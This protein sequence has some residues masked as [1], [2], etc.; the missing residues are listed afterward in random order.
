MDRR[1]TRTK[2][3]IYLAFFDLLK[4][5]PMDEITITELAKAADID[6]RTFYNHYDTVL[7][8]FLEFKGDLQVALVDLLEESEAAGAEAGNPMDFSTF[9]RGLNTIME[10]HREFY[11]KLSKDKASMFLRYDCKDILEA[12][13]KEFYGNRYENPKT[14]LNV[15]TGYIAYAITGLGSDYVTSKTP[16]PADEF[17]AQLI[18]PLEAIWV[19]RK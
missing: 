6:R 17:W 15:Y 9:F 12:A 10:E 1:Q 5:K 8:V 4:K 11:E 19:P 14:S 13:L 18:P 7:D 3:N 16:V 2:R